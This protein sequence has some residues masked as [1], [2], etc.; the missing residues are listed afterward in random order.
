MSDKCFLD[1]NIFVYSY[2]RS[3][4][5]KRSRA[6]ELIESALQ[7]HRGVISTQVFQ[8]FLNVST[9][10]FAKRLTTHD[11]YRYLDSVLA[12]LCEV[13]P[14]VALYRSALEVRE[15]TRYSFYDSLIVAAAL[16]AGCTTLYSED[17]RD[18]HNVRGLRIRDPFRASV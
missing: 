3:A 11:S 8:E 12:P 13:F 4:K 9:T 16:H 15:E 2:D 14:S 5:A 18:G 17:L 10:K 6:Q 1:T 7:T